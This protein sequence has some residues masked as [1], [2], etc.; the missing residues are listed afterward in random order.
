MKNTD[1]TIA[2]SGR[3]LMISKAGPDGRGRGVR[4]ARDHAVGQALLDHQRAEVRHVRDHVVR[5]F[6]ADALVRAQL[7][8]QRGEAVAQRGGL[9][10]DDRPGPG[11]RG[12]CRGR[13]PSCGS[14]PP[15]RAASGRTHRG[16]AAPRR[17]A[18]SR[19]SA[20]SGST[21]RRLAARARSSS[22]CSNII[23]VT[24]VGAGH[25]QPLGQLG[26]VHVGLE[27]AERGLRLAR[28]AR[29]QLAVQREQL[30]G[31]REGAGRHREHRG[32]GR[33]PGRPAPGCRGRAARPGSAARPAI[34]GEPAECAASAPMIR[35]ARSP[36]VT[37]TQPVV[38]FGR[39][40]G[41]IAPPKTKSS[42]SRASPASSPS[43][44]S[45][46][47]VSTICAH[48]RRG[49]RGLVGQHVHRHVRRA[50]QPLRPPRS[51]SAGSTRLAI[52]AITS[53]PRL[54]YAW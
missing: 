38:S 1:E 24:R 29:A 12:R 14:R 32:A 35:S 42:A 22:A 45:A 16:A 49:Q 33:E 20:P 9:R 37:T 30:G 5:Q 34:G 50:A 15:R 11:R 4:R 17:R 6:V 3:V 48:R 39:K 54:V 18:G 51:T 25:R 7:R 46:P 26:G 21:M 31:G 8:V 44:T 19:S 2:A 40:V 52:I 10:V 28:G 53:Q 13:R 41:S 27:Q 23:G 47:S 43:S 36:G